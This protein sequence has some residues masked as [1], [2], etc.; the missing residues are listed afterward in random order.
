MNSSQLIEKLNRFYDKLGSDKKY[1]FLITGKWGIGKTHTYKEFAREKE[2]KYYSLFG[3]SNLRELEVMMLKENKFPALNKIESNTETKFIRNL[4]KGFLKDK[5][6]LQNTLEAISINNLVEMS[7]IKDLNYSPKSIVCFDDLERCKIPMEDLMGFIERVKQKTNVVVLCNKDVIDEDQKKVYKTYKEKVIDFTYS[8][9]EI[10][11][12]VILGKLKSSKLKLSADMEIMILEEFKQHCKDNLRVLEKLVHLY[13]ELM[14]DLEERELTHEGK[15]KLLRVCFY[16]VCENELHLIKEYIKNHWNRIDNL[17]NSSSQFKQKEEIDLEK[18]KMKEEEFRLE[19]YSNVYEFYNK[20]LCERIENYYF[21]AKE[22]INEIVIELGWKLDKTSGFLNNCIKKY[23]YLT[24]EGHVE[25]VKKLEKY[26]EENNQ[27][28]YYNQRLSVELYFHYLYL[29]EVT[30]LNPK[31]EIKKFLIDMIGNYPRY[32][33]GNYW[34]LSSLRST[35]KGSIYK[36]FSEEI[37]R[38]SDEVEKRHLEEKENNFIELIKKKEY[39]KA[40]KEFI[41]F[42]KPNKFPAAVLEYFDYDFSNKMTFEEWQFWTMLVS[43]LKESKFEKLTEL[44]K[45]IETHEEITTPRRECFLEI[46]NSKEI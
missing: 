13:E 34:S 41:K 21:G 6:K 27:K 40:E 15:K 28:E 25:L 39:V 24:T 5:I 16:I 7:T 45:M 8:L 9:E 10:E 37:K 3:I 1:S 44:R 12:E 38:V 35:F 22:N 4:I 46:L 42:I 17:I 30:S 23:V 29:C 36:K 32:E 19:K 26:V 33:M 43:L 20:N 18:R 31:N 2:Q 14:F 11:D